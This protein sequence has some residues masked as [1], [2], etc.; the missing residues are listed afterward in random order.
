MQFGL[1]F[2]EPSMELPVCLKNLSTGRPFSVYMCLQKL[3]SKIG[4]EANYW[5]PMNLLLLSDARSERTLSSRVQHSRWLMAA[6]QWRSNL[7][8]LQDTFRLQQSAALVRPGMQTYRPLIYLRQL[9][10]G[11]RDKLPEAH[12]RSLEN[13]N[14]DLGGD[15][16]NLSRDAPTLTKVLA[17]IMEDLKK[18][19]RE[20]NDEIHLVI[21]AVTVQDSDATK[22]QTERATLLTL[23]AAVYLPLTLVTGIFGMNIKDIDD[24]K[25]SWRACG[26]VLA[27]V[28]AC[29]IVFV[30]AYRYWRRWQRGRQERERLEYGFNKFV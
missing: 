15:L 30:F 18:L 17:Q 8:H 16:G 27:V 20:L 21:G 6:Q 22:Q 12:R 28:A 2:H 25:P 24:G 29:T 5:D 1:T 10:V 11:M 9:I 14:G 26:E 4:A 3:I 19:D 7:K 23:I 13:D